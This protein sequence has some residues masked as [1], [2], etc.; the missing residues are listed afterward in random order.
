MKLDMKVKISQKLWDY[1][2]ENQRDL[3]DGGDHL[4]AHAK[5]DVFGNRFIFHDY[6]FVVFPFAKAYEGFL[7]QLFLDAGYINKADYAS[8]HFRVGKVLT[9]FLVKRLRER[10]VYKK[11]CDSVGCNFAD[12]LWETWKQGRNLVFHYYPHNLKSLSLFEAE[13][14]ALLIVKTMEE[15]IELMGEAIMKRKLANISKN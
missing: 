10:S 12:R 9:P 3:L 2:S 14:I 15:A 7:K 8:D 11:I 4:L 13:E 5:E 1:L 6:S